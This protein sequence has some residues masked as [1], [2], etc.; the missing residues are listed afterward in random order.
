MSQYFLFLKSLC[1]PVCASTLVSACMCTGLCQYRHTH[2][3]VQYMCRS[4]DNSGVTSC[5][6]PCFEERSLLCFWSLWAS[7]QFSWLCFL[8]HRRYASYRITLLNL[9]V[10]GFQE[11]NP[12]HLAWVTNAFTSW[13]ISQ[14]QNHSFWMM[15]LASLHYTFVLAESDGFSMTTLRWPAPLIPDRTAH[16]LG[17]WGEH[18]C[19]L[20]ASL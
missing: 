7:K 14:S 5:L 20:G 12:G 1:M 3:K 13:V 11:S 8:S 6:L 17:P 10:H 15:A 9:T 16:S 4:K 18:R 19:S 2:T